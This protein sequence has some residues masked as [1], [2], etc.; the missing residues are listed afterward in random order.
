MQFAFAF[1][2]VIF[3]TDGLRKRWLDFINSD[4]IVQNETFETE[5]KGPAGQ[6]YVTHYYLANYF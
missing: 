3:F 2:R 5:K 1:Y 4:L 6:D